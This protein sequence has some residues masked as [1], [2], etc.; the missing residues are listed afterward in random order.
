MA[1]LFPHDGEANARGAENLHHAAGNLSGAT[2]VTG[3]ATHPVEDVVVFARF[4]HG[5]VEAVR[6]LETVVGVEPP[7]VA[8]RRDVFEGVGQALGEVALFEREMTTQTHEEFRNRNVRGT[9]ARTGAAGRATPDDVLVD[10]FAWE[11][12]VRGIGG[13][14]AHR[15]DKVA[16]RKRGARAKGGTH[17]VAAAA[18]GA[19]VQGKALGLRE[20]RRMDEAE[21]FLLFNV[22]DL[23]KRSRGRSLAAIDGGG[24]AV[25]VGV[26]SKRNRRDEGER[27][28]AVEGPEPDVHAAKGFGR[29]ARRK[30]ELR[31]ERPHGGEMHPGGLFDG[32][33]QAFDDEA[34]KHHDRKRHVG[35][36]E[37]QVAARL[38]SLAVAAQG[39]HEKREENGDPGHVE[40]ELVGEVDVSLQELRADHVVTDVPVKGRQ[41][42]AE[43]EKEKADREYRMEAPAR[44]LEVL[45][46]I[47]D[48]L[49]HSEEALFDGRLGNGRSVETPVADN[50]PDE[51]GDGGDPYEVDADLSPEGDVPE[52]GTN[53]KFCGH[54]RDSENSTLRV[55]EERGV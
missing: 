40:D 17:V 8:D 28:K 3:G 39:A 2:V 25:E 6:P 42:G 5:N 49:D 26:E 18:F 52:A 22:F 54:K 38:A 41:G 50:A 55:P 21:G 23:G 24:R 10:G 19:A 29:E 4:R 11:R 1:A 15:G 46:L 30:E 9:G 45:R 16:R 44:R 53:R 36:E 48:A 12:R 31:D 32:E 20:I 14:A 35:D 13:G 47:K 27:Q 37:L 7:G 33:A 43:K 34:R 51:N